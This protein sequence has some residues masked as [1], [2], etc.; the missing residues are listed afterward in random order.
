MSVTEQHKEEAAVNGEGLAL[1]EPKGHCGW[2]W[3]PSVSPSTPQGVLRPVLFVIV[4]LR[5]SVPLENLQSFVVVAAADYLNMGSLSSRALP[6][7][8]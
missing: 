7:A 8:L 5:R 3:L 6:R 1:C 4:P 2:L